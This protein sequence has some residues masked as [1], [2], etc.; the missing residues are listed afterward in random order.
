[1]F[2]L[3][4]LVPVG[5]LAPFMPSAIAAMSLFYAFIFFAAFPVGCQ[6]AALQEISPNQMRAQV[7]ALYLFISN[8]FGIGLDPTFIAFF[9]DIVFK[10]DLAV[11][12]SM[13]IAVAIA[14][15]IGVLFFWRGLKPY[16]DSLES[17][18]AGY[19]EP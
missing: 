1:M 18:A 3:V 13:S 8:M 17:A 19:Q 14:C 12:S 7:T 10:N 6:A 11:G 5:I 16:R 15:P 9:T 4:C 2:A